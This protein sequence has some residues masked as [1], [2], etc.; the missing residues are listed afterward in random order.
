MTSVFNEGY[1]AF[2]GVMAKEIEKDFNE[3]NLEYQTTRRTITGQDLRDAGYRPGP[4]YKTML[5]ALQ[6]ARDSPTEYI[7]ENST[8]YA[9]LEWLRSHFWKNMIECA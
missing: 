8:V 1:F 7:T 6:Q 3:R 9:Q 4:T 5:E 2:L